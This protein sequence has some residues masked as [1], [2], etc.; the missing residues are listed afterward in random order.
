MNLRSFQGSHLRLIR[1]WCPEIPIQQNPGLVSNRAGA[2]QC[3]RPFCP[4]HPDSPCLRVTATVSLSGWAL[5]L[6]HSGPSGP[7]L[8]QVAT[9]SSFPP[10]TSPQNH[11][12]P[13]H[14]LRVLLQSQ[15]RLDLWG[16]LS[17]SL[18]THT[19]T[20][21]VQGP[22][23]VCNGLSHHSKCATEAP[24]P[25]TAGRVDPPGCLRI[26]SVLSTHPGS[27]GKDMPRPASSPRHLPPVSFFHCD[28]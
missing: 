28:P 4:F 27:A 19:H 25:V 26:G 21:S 7:H 11:H 15:L 3:P 13:H 2:H 14:C 5:A 23:T 20:P 17:P 6:L 16:A 22:C 10:A 9:T 18:G 24:C 1:Q 8:H 12:R